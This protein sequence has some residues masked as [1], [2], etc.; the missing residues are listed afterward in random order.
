ME[1]SA[2]DYLAIKEQA[3]RK[4]LTE[5]GVDSSIIEPLRS[6]RN[7]F[8]SRTK[9]KFAVAGTLNHPVIGMLDTDLRGIELINC[10]L[11]VPIINRAAARL[12]QTITSAKLVPY[13]AHSRRGELKYLIVSANSTQTELMI[14]FVL[15]S[16]ESVPRIQKALPELQAALPE[17]RVVSCNIQPKPAAILEGAEELVLTAS[18]SI[19]EEYNGVVLNFAPQS[20]QQV[21]PE[22]AAALYRRAA[23]AAAHERP[24]SALDL[25]CG[26]GG[27]ALAVAPH[28]AHITGIEL[29]HSAIACAARAAAAAGLSSRTEFLCGDVANYLRNLAAFAFDL[30]IVNPPRRGLGEEIVDSILRLSPRLLFY[31]SC[32]PESLTKDM[33]RLRSAYSVSAAA[34]FDMFPLTSHLELFV[35][36]HRKP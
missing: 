28:V 11:H 1:R 21:T 32:N 2:A 35:A 27:F 31:S 5:C 33:Q 24:S 29:S 8:Q 10:P 18:G 26:V 20:F 23:Q 34:P 36:M 19:S 15:R 7:P 13:D 22:I 25:F 3:A 17:L 9:A 30:I 12:S 14:R 4:A 16:T 6:P